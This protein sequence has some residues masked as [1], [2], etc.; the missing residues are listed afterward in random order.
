MVSCQ[1]EGSFLPETVIWNIL[2]SENRSVL[3]LPRWWKSI[4]EF[5]VY[6]CTRAVSLNWL[7]CYEAPRYSLRGLEEFSWHSCARCLNL[8][9]GISIG[10]PEWFLDVKML[11]KRQ[12][13]LLILLTSKAHWESQ[14]GTE[15]F[16]RRLRW[17]LETGDSL[18]LKQTKGYSSFYH[19]WVLL[20]SSILMLKKLWKPH[21]ILRGKKKSVKFFF[22]FSV[23]NL[24]LPADYAY[25]TAT[26]LKLCE[27]SHGGCK[28]EDL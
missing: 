22:P 12:D 5:N 13:K 2:P 9:T 23:T 19:R 4:P 27:E 15:G 7:S 1:K 25:G 18:K 11:V 10:V 20:T 24:T 14:R 8:A 17:P 26:S 16:S 21:G 6:L 28:T 3:W